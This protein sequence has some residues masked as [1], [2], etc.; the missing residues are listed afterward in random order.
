MLD[1]LPKTRAQFS[2]RRSLSLGEAGA[3]F[4][5]TVV[6]FG[7][8][9][10]HTILGLSVISALLAGAFGFLCVAGMY[11]LHLLIPEGQRLFGESEEL[12]RLRSRCAGVATVF[13]LAAAFVWLF[14]Y[15][16]FVHHAP[17]IL[18]LPV[19]SA[20][21][22]IAFVGAMAAGI[23]FRLYRRYRCVLNELRLRKQENSEAGV[24][25]T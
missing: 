10:V 20:S 5:L 11:E 19:M 24:R 12:E 9:A 21:L 18:E 3:D 1:T 2:M 4:A 23:S 7:E 22:L 6:L 8:K 13:A 17:G 15:P 16:W 14:C 25:E